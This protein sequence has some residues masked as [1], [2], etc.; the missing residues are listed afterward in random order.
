ML[1]GG[2]DDVDGGQKTEGKRVKTEVNGKDG[3]YGADLH[4]V[5]LI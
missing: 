2:G 4:I 3:K 1:R 5:E